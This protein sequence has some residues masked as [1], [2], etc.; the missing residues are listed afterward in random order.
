MAQMEARLKITAADQTSASFRAIE[1]KIQKL[2]SITKHVGSEMMRVENTANY[3]AKYR[4]E[5]RLAALPRSAVAQAASVRRAREAGAGIGGGTMLA[6]GAALGG[7]LPAAL[8]VGGAGLLAKRALDAYASLEAKT[9]SLGVTAEA[10]GAQVRAAMENFRE[11]GP[12]FGAT[13]DDVSGAAEKFVAAGLSFKDAVAA[14]PAALKAAK[15]SGAELDDIA[16][17][18]VASMQNLG[19]AADKLDRA[20][21][22]MAKGGKLGSFE[23]KNMARELPG[24]ASRASALK[25]YGEQGLTQIVA[26]AETARRTA[27]SGAEAANNLVNFFDKILSPDTAKHFKDQGVDLQRVLE[28]NAKRGVDYVTTTLRLVEKMTNGDDF[29]ISKLFPDKEARNA[30][31]ALLAFKG[32]YLGAVAEMNRSAIGTNVEDLSRRLGITKEKIAQ[33]ASA[34]DVL[35]GR[36]GEKLAPAAN[37]VLDKTLAG[38]NA[39][40]GFLAPTPPAPPPSPREVEGLRAAAADFDTRRAGLANAPGPLGPGSLGTGG[41]IAAAMAAGAAVAAAGLAARSGPAAKKRIDEL[42]QAATASRSLMGLAPGTGPMLG[43]LPLPPSMRQDVV[44]AP[45]VVAGGAFTLDRRASAYDAAT[46]LPK[47]LAPR[48]EPVRLEGAADIG[49]TVRIEAPELMRAYEQSR[50]VHARGALSAD[51]GVSMTEAAPRR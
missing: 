36:L 34:W 35:L 20:Y 41:G 26:M 3:V 10:T 25:L 4:I 23:L 38:L 39:A 31:K 48:S 42:E 50:T 51:T 32:E 37:I 14:T 8:G 6:A 12:Q 21:D 27:P 28:E 33:V 29:K 40:N 9:M 13:A 24:L 46:G 7:M 17:A 16:E 47:I 22:V 2:S 18:G 45:G 49:I 19:I 1:E 11:L 43:G 15:A 30:V 44:G 5:N